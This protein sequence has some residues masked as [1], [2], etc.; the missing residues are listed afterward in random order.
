MSE[1][2]D[3]GGNNLLHL[4]IQIKLHEF[5]MSKFEEYN[6][7]LITKLKQLNEHIEMVFIFSVFSILMN[8]SIL[9]LIVF[10]LTHGKIVVNF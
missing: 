8:I 10:Y 3:G 7:L 1:Q 5:Y 4:S 9:A 2:N 6:E